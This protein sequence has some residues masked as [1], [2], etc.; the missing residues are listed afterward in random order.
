MAL[1][2]IALLVGAPRLRKTI[3]VTFVVMFGE[4]VAS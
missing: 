3:F 1:L 4:T 2:E